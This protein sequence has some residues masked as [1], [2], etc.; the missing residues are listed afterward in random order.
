MW[1][2][3]SSSTSSYSHHTRST[4]ATCNILNIYY[5]NT[6]SIK[7][8]TQELYNQ[9][10]LS[11]YDIVA[12]AETW[13]DSSV[14][15]AELAPQN[16]T[17]FRHDRN[18]ESTGRSRG[19]GVLIAVRG[20]QSELVHLKAPGLT[21]SPLIDLLCIK[22]STHRSM[23]YVVLVYIPPQ[24]PIAEYNNL[25]D[26]LF[27]N[28]GNKIH[29]TDMLFLGDFN[30]PNYAS[31]FLRNGLLDNY[32]FH[33]EN[34]AN[35]FQISQCNKVVNNDGRL[36]D[37]VFF[38]RM[39][40]VHMAT[41]VLTRIDAHHPPLCIAF[42]YRPVLNNNKEAPKNNCQNYNFRKA[43]FPLLYN[44]ISCLDWTFLDEVRDLEEACSMLYTHLYSVFD[45][46]VPKYGQARNRVYPPGF[47]SI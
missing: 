3:A 17:I 10:S 16:F 40:T 8:V 12:L 44:K 27:I 15:D 13:L 11:D 31:F 7:N 9:L 36:L 47:L 4:P 43:N 22:V 20:L 14:F 45:Q 6:R 46:C 30:I 41:D 26:Y 2:P 42:S 24:L 19:G 37:L 18:F 35:L 32:I 23:I 28:F 38:N 1:P 5:Q 34:F 21:L 39:C 29:S 33:L 25:Y